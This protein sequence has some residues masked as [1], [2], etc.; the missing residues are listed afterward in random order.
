MPTLHTNYHLERNTCNRTTI[1]GASCLSTN[2]TRRI[3]FLAWMLENIGRCLSATQKFNVCSCLYWVN[4]GH[5]PYVSQ[6]M[7]SCACHVRSSKSLAEPMI[8][9][10]SMVTYHHKFWRK[11]LNATKVERRYTTMCLIAANEFIKLECSK[12]QKGDTLGVCR[13]FIR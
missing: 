6:V 10:K 1:Q 11:C 9:S 5:T 2:V 8:T 3:S 4:E 13:I 12:P 7:A